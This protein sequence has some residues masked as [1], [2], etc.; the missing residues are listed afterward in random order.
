LP[1]VF[2][3][4]ISERVDIAASVFINL[5]VDVSILV[6]VDNNALVT[7]A[8]RAIFSNPEVIS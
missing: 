1:T 2:P 4:R 6:W 3:Y 8:E 5:D 7:P